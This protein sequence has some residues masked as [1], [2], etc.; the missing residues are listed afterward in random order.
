[1]AREKVS[2]VIDYDSYIAGTQD[3]C[4][5]YQ[6]ST[7]QAFSLCGYTDLYIDRAGQET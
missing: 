7:G 1:L 5:C 4:L 2:Q 6:G 3:L